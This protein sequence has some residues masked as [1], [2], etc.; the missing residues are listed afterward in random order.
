MAKKSKTNELSKDKKMIDKEVKKAGL[1][2]SAIAGAIIVI[3]GLLLIIFNL[4]G[5]LLA[6][7]GLVLIY[8]GLRMLGYNIKI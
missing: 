6:F 2:Y 7:I 5:V 1:T 4:P 8:F 3:I